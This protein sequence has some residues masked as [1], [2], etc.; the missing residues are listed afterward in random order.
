M[1]FIILCNYVIIICVVIALH[2]MQLL[3]GRNNGR[4]ASAPRCRAPKLEG[5]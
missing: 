3:H 5:S 2:A 1:S 4:A